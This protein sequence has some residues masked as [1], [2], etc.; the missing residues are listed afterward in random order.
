MTDHDRNMRTLIVC[1][2]LAMGVLIPL[3]FLEGNTM[4]NQEVKVLGETEELIEEPDLSEETFEVIETED[5]TDGE[6]MAEFDPTL[7]VEDIIL[8]EVGG[9]N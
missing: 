6:E 5:V 3:R 8:P 7:E 4:M 9:L 2:V 1:F